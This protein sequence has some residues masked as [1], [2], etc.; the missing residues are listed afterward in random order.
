MF[1]YI[2]VNACGVIGHI[3]K[4]SGKGTSVLLYINE[5][6]KYGQQIGSQSVYVHLYNDAERVLLRH[7]AAIGDTLEIR[8]GNLRMP[9]HTP[10][11]SLVSTTI[12]C[13]WYNQ[14]SVI[15]KSNYYTLADRKRT[16]TA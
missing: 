7:N 1:Q 9:Y 15:A 11:G 4:M 5:L 14:I 13:N 16:C 12:N 3:S 6:D 10:N 8:A 2:Q